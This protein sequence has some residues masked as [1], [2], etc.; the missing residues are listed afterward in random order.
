ML[1][2][3]IIHANNTISFKTWIGRNWSDANRVSVNSQIAPRGRVGLSADLDW[4]S[5]L[6]AIVRAASVWMHL[7]STKWQFPNKNIFEPY[8]QRSE[9][10]YNEWRRNEACSELPHNLHF[11]FPELAWHSGCV[12]HYFLG[13]DSRCKN[14]ASRP[15]QGTVNGT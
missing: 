8:P 15:S 4:K 14:R 12:M 1:L 11:T 5:H 7:N 10:F 9:R 13:F 2:G 3:C 6:V